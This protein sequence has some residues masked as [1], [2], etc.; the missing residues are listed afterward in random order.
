MNKVRNQNL[1]VARDVASE[2][3]THF[4]I[5]ENAADKLLHEEVTNMYN[6]KVNE[7]SDKLTSHAEALEEYAHQFNDS[8]G[9]MEIK[10][11]S[12]NLIVM[13]FSQNPFQQIKTTESGIYLDTGGMAPE[14]KSNET[15]EIEEEEQF[16]IVATVMDAG[17]D[18]K[19]IKEGDVVMYTRPSQLPIP[20][21]RQNIFQVNEV[22][23]MCVINSGLTE[24]FNNIKK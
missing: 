13:P 21:Y 10:A 1:K 24:R 15:G 7:Y 14:Y 5:N 16:I 12:N 17:P 11:I 19:W 22:R 9:N 8:I 4:I 18:C 23:I 2:E 6:E 3:G 20:F